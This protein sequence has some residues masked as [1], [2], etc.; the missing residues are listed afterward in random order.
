M[1][2]TITFATQNTE[3][4]FSNLLAMVPCVGVALAG[5]VGTMTTMEA[6][7][8]LTLVD[9]CSSVQLAAATASARDIDL[10]WSPA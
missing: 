7:T 8:A 1:S 4:G 6:S 2:P 10:M 9:S 3:A 5:A